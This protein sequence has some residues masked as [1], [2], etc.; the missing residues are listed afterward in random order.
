MAPK[1]KLT[2]FDIQAFGEPIRFLLKYGGIEFEDNRIQF[3]DWP[4]L[5]SSEWPLRFMVIYA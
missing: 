1:Y 5:K 2:Y 4:Q 3:S